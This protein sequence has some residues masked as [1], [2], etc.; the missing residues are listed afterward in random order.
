MFK[1]IIPLLCVLLLLCG[2]LLSCAQSDVDVPED[3]QIA[4]LEGEPFY[5]FVPL[6]WTPNLSSGVSGAYISSTDTI[7]V[8]ARHFPAS[9]GITLDEY[10]SL[11]A[12]GYGKTYDSFEKAEQTAA[13]LGG[14]DAVKLSYKIKKGEVELTC[15]QI[16]TLYRG[17]VIS[18]SAYCATELYETYKEDF[19]R[20]V[21]EF[22]LT[23]KKTEQAA[24]L[25]DKHTP[26]GMKIAS[27]EQL[28][29]V[30]Y[31]PTTWICTPTEGMSDAYFSELDKSN[32][33]VTSFVPEGSTSVKDYF[34]TCE[35]TYQNVLDSYTRL[36]EAE[37][38]VAERTA[39]TYVY[40]A[41]DGELTYRISQTLFAY[42][43]MI[44]SITYTALDEQFDAHL[45]DVEKI[46]NA[47][48]FR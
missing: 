8:S 31:V 5:L 33:S 28:E 27:A 29:Y 30:F 44:Y 14:E 10:V 36:S 13:V 3:M 21:K 6:N 18:L 40:S 45:G 2:A 12:E 48:R 25:T 16:C 22:R 47:F 41:K 43:D 39:Y 34:D 35:K 15:F 17:D 23:E 11:C 32:V 1:K 46:L 20:I 38:T 9:E 24:P 26:E 42:N 19:N 4:T 37:R 7:M